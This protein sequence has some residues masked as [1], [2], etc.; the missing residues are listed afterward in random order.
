[1]P[2]PETRARPGFDINTWQPWTEP[3]GPRSGAAFDGWNR[4]A[5]ELLDAKGES[6]AR[7]LDPRTAKYFDVS[8]KLLEEAERQKLAAGNTP[9]RW[10]FAENGAEQTMST[11]LPAGIR[12]TVTPPGY[13]TALTAPG[14]PA[15]PEGMA[16]PRGPAAARPPA[17][18]PGGIDF[19]RL[20]LRHVSSGSDAIG[21]SFKTP[22]SGDL[23]E[24]DLNAIDDASDAFFVWLELQP[25]QFWVNLNPGQ[26]ETIIDAD[27]GRTDVGRVMLLADLQLKANLTTLIDPNGPLGDEFIRRIF[28]GGP[29]DDTCVSVRYFI[30]PLPATVRDTGSELYILD[31]PLNVKSETLYTVINGVRTCPNQTPERAQYNESVVRS[32]LVPSLTRAVN[33]DPEY[34]N[35]RRVYMSRVAAEWYRQVSATKDTFYKPLINDGVV[36]PFVS[37]EPWNPKDI[38]DDFVSQL[39]SHTFTANLPQPVGEITFTFGGIDLSQAPAAPMDAAQ[40]TQQYPQLPA[41]VQESIEKP[42]KDADG[43]TTWAGGRT[44]LQPIPPEAAPAQQQPSGLAV[45]GTSKWFWLSGL[46][47][48]V[49]GVLL[50]I[51]SRRRRRLPHS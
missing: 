32:V 47:L 49:G 8:A 25:S 9:V 50:V 38:W 6:Y 51:L 30:E 2:Y 39:Y 33:N 18:A 1:V 29:D 19:S 15:D 40:F 41:T 20:Q 3:P 11:R 22:T 12:T 48:C 42:A 21:Y 37:K 16:A 4:A 5:G 24:G 34:A 10:H 14:S 28:I 23:T 17:R 7:L 13:S 45:T 46:L 31:A 43:Q 26:P 44:V 36:L 27:L 35:L